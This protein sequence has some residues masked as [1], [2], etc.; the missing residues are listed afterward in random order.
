MERDRFEGQEESEGL[1]FL[2][3]L[4]L[5]DRADEP[6]PGRDVTLGQFLEIC[7]DHARPMLA[8]LESLDPSDPRYDQARG[9]LHDHVVENYLNPPSE[10]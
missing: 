6:I 3:L 7:G 1:K 9:A 8:G 5:E 4:G 10:E 2:K